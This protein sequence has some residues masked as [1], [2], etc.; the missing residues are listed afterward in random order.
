VLV[1]VLCCVHVLYDCAVR[2]LTF[3]SAKRTVILF[4]VTNAPGIH[5]PLPPS[6]FVLYAQGR[7]G[8]AA[9]LI[10]QALQGQRRI[11]GE[12][13]PACLLAAHTLGLLY[14]A[15]GNLRACE[16]LLRQALGRRGLI[17]SGHPDTLRCMEVLGAVLRLHGKHMEACPVI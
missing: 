10:V 1:L 5:L 16:T 4:T 17:G 3:C 2:S 13:H 8:E 11:L 15:T 7:L 14:F 12:S 6:G 9:P